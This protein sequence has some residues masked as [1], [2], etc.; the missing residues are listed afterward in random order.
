METSTEVICKTCGK[1]EIVAPSR[2]KKYKNCSRECMGIYNSVTYSQKKKIECWSCGSTFLVKTSHVDKRKTCSKACFAEYQKVKM[3][4]EG[5]HQYGLKG[6]LN[7]SFKGLEIPKVNHRNIDIR[8]YVPDHPYADSNGRVLKHRY[9]AEQNFEEF[10]PDCFDEING[11]K[12]LKKKYDVHHKDHNHSNDDLKNL[13]VMTRGEHT[14]H[15]NKYKKIVR[16][17]LGKIKKIIVHE[18]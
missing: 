18:N 14:A 16:D 1:K 17:K 3:A 15:H 12:V 13:E 10:S 6:H 7:A 11:Y 8:V 4:G 2:A 9:I 5:N